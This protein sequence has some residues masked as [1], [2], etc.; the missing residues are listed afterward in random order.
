MGLCDF[1]CHLLPLIDDGYVSVEGFSRMLSLY[2]ES[3][4]S[5]IA[6]T[7]HIYNPYVTTN[8]GSLRATFTWASK[9]ALNMGITTYLGSELFVGTQPELKCLPIAD[10]YCLVEFG[11]SLPPANLISRLEKLQDEGLTLI[12]AHVER[13]RWLNP[14]SPMMERL[15][16]LGALVQVNVEAVEDGSALSYI[17]SGL[18]DL[19]ATDNHGD[20]TLPSRMLAVLNEWPEV[21]K[22]MEGMIL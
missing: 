12:L 22:K 3:G 13:Y 6:F 8:I 9:M 10:K 17:E 19:V 11:L 20:E 16:S 5:S 21:Y 7:P 4:V 2:K 18:V 14:T 15:L 1:H